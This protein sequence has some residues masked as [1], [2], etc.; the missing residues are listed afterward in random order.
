MERNR[1]GRAQASAWLLMI[2]LL[3]AGNAA[4]AADVSGR[5]GVGITILPVCHIS[6]PIMLSQSVFPAQGVSIRC[7]KGMS[8]KLAITPPAR[9]A[10]GSAVTPT[11]VDV[12][13]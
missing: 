1:T 6:T 5:L 4:Q 11:L 12:T 9:Q 8:Y 7:P 13:F 10:A 2:G 3:L